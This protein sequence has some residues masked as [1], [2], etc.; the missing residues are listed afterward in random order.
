ML[1]RLHATVQHS[2]I[3]ADVMPA[4]TNVHVCI[5]CAGSAGQAG[6]SDAAAH[7]ADRLSCLEA[8]LTHSTAANEAMSSIID[9]V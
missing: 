9:Q 4:F 6:S 5:G 1:Q 8:D 7:V 3:C 2:F